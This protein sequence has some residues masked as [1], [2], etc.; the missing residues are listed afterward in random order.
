MASVRCTGRLARLLVAAVAVFAAAA[1]LPT[2]HAQF[3]AKAKCSLPPSEALRRISAR[4]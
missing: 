1:V 3:P 4:A 2:A